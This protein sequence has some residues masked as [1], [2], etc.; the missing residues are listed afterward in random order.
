VIKFEVRHFWFM[1]KKPTQCIS[2]RLLWKNWTV[3]L[4]ITGIWKPLSYPFCSLE[5]LK[6]WR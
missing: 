2:A 6:I 4:E 1:A 5:E 3:K